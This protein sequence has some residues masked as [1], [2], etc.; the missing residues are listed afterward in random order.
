VPVIV[1]GTG[2][3]VGVIVPFGG[4]SIM[5]WGFVSPLGPLKT[6]VVPAGMYPLAVTYAPTCPGPGLLIWLK[7]VS[8]SSSVN[9]II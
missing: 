4:G 7:S 8:A 5:I 1:I 3:S 6:S 2:A 9:V